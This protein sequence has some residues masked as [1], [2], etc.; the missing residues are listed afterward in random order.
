MTRL[1][2][3]GGALRLHRNDGG[4]EDERGGAVSWW[5]CAMV[6]RLMER[7]C[8][9]ETIEQQRICDPRGG[10]D[11]A[12]ERE[13]KKRGRRR[14]DLCGG[15]TVVKWLACGGWTAPVVAGSNRGVRGCARGW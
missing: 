11:A 15:E 9:T 13:R 7:F 14:G 1:G 8:A 12:R 5:G 3:V 10:G 4:W 6:R 2:F